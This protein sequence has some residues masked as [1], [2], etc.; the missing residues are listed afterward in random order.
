MIKAMVFLLITILAMGPARA[1]IELSPLRQVLTNKTRVATFTLS[2]PSARIIDGRVTWVD[3]SA[4]Q[5]GYAPADAQTRAGLS[6][7]PYL[8]LTPAQFRLEPGARTEVTVRLKDGARPPPGER[9][10]HL[11]VETSAART[12]IRKAS[13]GLQ[14]DIAVG[15]SVPVL[16]R[17][18]GCGAAVLSETKLLR[19]GDGLLLISTAIEP[20]GAY[21]T[22][23][24]LTATFLPAAADEEPEL[25]GVRDNVAGYPDAPHRLVEIPFGF[26]SLGAGELTLRY[27]GGGEYAGRIFDERSFTIAPPK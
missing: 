14:A 10:S 13:S 8:T 6:A 23:G 4:T 26:F 9:R 2:N 22:Y 19:D 20:T 18:R 5:T 16:L 1:D 12:L 7:A 21:S 15:V 25:L 24:R 17:G 11:L 3:L 27:E